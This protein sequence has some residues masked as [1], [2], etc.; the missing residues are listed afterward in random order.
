[1]RIDLHVHV[2]DARE[3]QLDRIEKLVQAVF[4]REAQMSQ[5]L[6]DLKAQVTE[7]TQVEQSAITLING[8]AAQLQEA[9]NNGADPATLQAMHDELKAN[10]DALAA[11]VAANT[12]PPPPPTA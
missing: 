11:A 10:S 4:N 7:T 1:M 6:D 12:P 9:I 3:Q 5:Q 8:I 2:H